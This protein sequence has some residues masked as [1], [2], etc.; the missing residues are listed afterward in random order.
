MSKAKH[1]VILYRYCDK[2]LLLK[3]KTRKV[4]AILV[5]S[6]KIKIILKVE[7]KIVESTQTASV[8]NRK[9]Q[10]Q[11][12]ETS[13]LESARSL[14]TERPHSQAKETAETE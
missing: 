5:P 3:P 11:V 8:R 2:N 4:M 6:R 9:R 1:E 14:H 7:Q 12:L 10:P 13:K